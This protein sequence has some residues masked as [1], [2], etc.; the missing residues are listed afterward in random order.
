MSEP[1]VD[2][3]EPSEIQPKK[4]VRRNVA[5]ALG[6]ICIILVAG[7]VTVYASM[8][9]AL[10]DKDTTI[11]S[12]SIQ[13]IFL[14]NQIGDL[15]DTLHMRKSATWAYEE[16]VSQPAGS[17]SVLNFAAP[18]AGRID[19]FVDYSTA[20][21]TYIRVIW[22]SSAMD[23]DKLVDNVTHSGQPFPVLPD[24]NVEV[25]IGNSNIMNEA[26]ETVT[27]FYHY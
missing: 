19:V 11:S 26:T 21:N 3:T 6:I 13:K 2:E 1:K 14:D 16:N 22:S 18:Y 24:S 4:M 27:I 25:R 12:L 8:V 5:V 7:L 17:Y 15:N 23:Y 10:A 9:N 20:N